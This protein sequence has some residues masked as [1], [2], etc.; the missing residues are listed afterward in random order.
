MAETHSEKIRI[1]VRSLLS[2]GIILHNND[3][4]VDDLGR[5]VDTFRDVDV[6]VGRAK[7]VFPNEYKD[8]AMLSHEMVD[9]FPI[10]LGEGMFGE[11]TMHDQTLPQ[12][13][14]KMMGMTVV[15]ADAKKKARKSKAQKVYAKKPKVKSKLSDDYKTKYRQIKDNGYDVATAKVMAKWSSNR[16]MQQFMEDGKI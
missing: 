1:A 15:T 14:A 11:H 5:I 6:I 9:T 4:T 12:L 7:R 16:I 8:P 10:V 3:Y 13:R 2:V